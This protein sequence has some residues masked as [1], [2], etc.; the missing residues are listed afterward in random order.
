MVILVNCWSLSVDHQRSEK[1]CVS[2]SYRSFCGFDLQENHSV[3]KVKSQEVFPHG[4]SRGMGRVTI[5]KYSQNILH[6]SCLLWMGKG[7]QSLTPPGERLFFSQLQPHLAFL[8][9]PWNKKRYETFVRSQTRGKYTTL[10][11]SRLPVSPK[12]EKKKTEKHLWKSQ[13]KD[14]GSL[15]HWDQIT[16]P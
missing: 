10:A 14:K 3:L 11:S 16:E 13:T 1:F 5:L 2:Q 6:D 12:K 7:Y 15:K 4:Y 9:L 8:I